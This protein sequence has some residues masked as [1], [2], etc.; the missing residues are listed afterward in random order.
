MDDTQLAEIQRS[1][2]RVEEAVAGIASWTAAHRIEDTREFGDIRQSFTSQ[3]K[4]LAALEGLADTVESHG[5]ALVNIET[6][7]SASEQ[8]AKVEIAT[9]ARDRMWLKWILLMVLALTTDHFTGSK[10]ADW[11]GALLK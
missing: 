3:D 11:V 10:I 6:R 4:R 7:L 9:R 8:S 5:D 2:G 1:L